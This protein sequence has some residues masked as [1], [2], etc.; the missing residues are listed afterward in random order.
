VERIRRI[1]ARGSSEKELE[2]LLVTGSG[3][4][5]VP[6]GRINE[7]PKVIAE[8][9]LREVERAMTMGSMKRA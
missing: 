9:H 4:V 6:K 7:I 5:Y 3:L 8:H 2:G 1:F